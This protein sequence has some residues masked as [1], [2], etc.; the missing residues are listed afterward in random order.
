MRRSKILA[1]LAA[2]LVL[3]PVLAR[4]ERCPD[5]QQRIFTGECV[6]KCKRKT[7]PVL[8][9]GCTEAPKLVKAEPMDE[10]QGVPSEY[11]RSYERLSQ[12]ELPEVRSFTVHFILEADGTITRT[13]IVGTGDVEL[14][15]GFLERVKSRV[16]E[17]AMVDGKPVAV[18]LTSTFSF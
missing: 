11:R 17:P 3:S 7:V 14:R 12:A 2:L 4:K 10:C 5:G 1:V 18:Y 13:E 6:A 9:G 16:Y 8:G 15:E